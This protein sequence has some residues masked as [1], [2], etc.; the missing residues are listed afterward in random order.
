M[1]RKL[2]KCSSP[3]IEDRLICVRVT[4]S[5]LSFQSMLS[6]VLDCIILQ[7]YF[8]IYSFMRFVSHSSS[9]K[10]TNFDR[11][12]WFSHV[13]LGRAL[14][15]VITAFFSSSKG[16]NRTLTYLSVPLQSSKIAR[17]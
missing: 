12:I 10:C 2:I 14:A 3:D 5:M 15:K 11:G 4:L 8:S 17:L 16:L 13:S 9:W 6:R 1:C 7:F